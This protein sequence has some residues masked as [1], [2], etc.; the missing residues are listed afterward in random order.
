VRKVVSYFCK[1]PLIAAVV[2][3]VLSSLILRDG[4]VFNPDGWGYWEASVSLLQGRGYQ[5]FGGHPIFWYPPLFPLYLMLWQAVLGIS[6]RTLCVALIVCCGVST[7]IWTEVFRRQFGAHRTWLH[8]ILLVTFMSC[9]LAAC[10]HVLFSEPLQL[11]F[12]GLLLLALTGA[13]MDDRPLTAGRFWRLNLWLGLVMILL[14]VCRNSSLAFAP[15]VGLFL[16]YLTRK[17]VGF[18]PR[19]RSE[20]GTGPICRNG[21]SGAAHKWGLSPFRSGSKT[22][23]ALNFAG[24]CTLVLVIPVGVWRLMRAL[25]HLGGNDARWF[26]GFFRPDTYFW[27][28]FEGNMGLLGP[29]YAG[30]ILLLVLCGFLVFATFLSPDLS[31]QPQAKVARFFLAFVVSSVTLF[32]LMVNLADVWEYLKGRYLWFVPLML[33]GTAIVQSTLLPASRWR[34]GVLGFLVVL[35]GFQVFRTGTFATFPPDQYAL[36]NTRLEFISVDFY[37]M[38][39]WAVY[40]IH[41]IE[42]ESTLSPDW[43]DAKIGFPNRSQKVE[44]GLLLSPPPQHWIDRE[45]D[46]KWKQ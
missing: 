40:P 44:N 23:F 18:S 37:N 41:H 24:A 5:Y 10:N 9:F 8:S 2:A 45:Y 7:F 15:A 1:E 12:Q 46:K 3:V 42:P 32:Y 20:K 28:I 4:I 19:S 38:H 16:L 36:P 17:Y 25:L 27:H 35:V 14:L 26:D 39:G 22:R 13:F 34:L 31:K 11:V 6:A 43:F 21:P 30:A 33:V 29:D